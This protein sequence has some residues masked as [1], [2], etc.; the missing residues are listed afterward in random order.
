VKETGIKIG[1]LLSRK[2]RAIKKLR[3]IISEYL[4]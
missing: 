1:T 2:N 3:D 4:V